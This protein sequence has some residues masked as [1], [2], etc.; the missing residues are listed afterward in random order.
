MGQ[1]LAYVFAPAL[2][3]LKALLVVNLVYWGAMF[4]GMIAT[5]VDESLQPALT[6]SV[7]EEFSPAG[8]MGPL[9]QAYAQN[10]FVD[11]TLLTFAA[12]FAIASVLFITLPSV[13]IPFAGLLMGVFRALMWGVLF[14]PFGGGMDPTFLLRMSPHGLTILLE[15]E[16]YIVAMLGVW[17]WW[18]SVV[19][20]TGKRWR[21][22]RSGFLLQGRVYLG[23]ISLLAVAATWEAFE[24]IYLIPE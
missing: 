17:L 9:A 8:T 13:A 24:L 14:S 18:P 10:Q 16:A 20:T 3:H 11:A 22:W 6:R 2:M 21:S 15:G 4:L 23:V 19:G 5:L 7:V 1:F 12:N